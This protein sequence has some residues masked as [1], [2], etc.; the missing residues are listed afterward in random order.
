MRIDGESVP[1]RTAASLVPGPSKR[2]IL[3]DSLRFLFRKPLL[4]AVVI[5]PVAF[6]DL[7]ASEIVTVTSKSPPLSVPAGQIATLVFGWSSINNTGAFAQITFSDGTSVP[8]GV[9]SVNGPLTIAGPC[10]VGFAI[11]AGASFMSFKLSP[12]IVDTP[13][14]PTGAVVIPADG[15]GNYNVSLESSTDLINWIVATPGTY[16]SGATNRFFRV[17]LNKSS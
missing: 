4:L 17:R 2:R 16:G 13:L 14:I 11:N 8:A 6:G 3:K 5:S 15:S 7:W 9:S 1:N 10:T 12:S